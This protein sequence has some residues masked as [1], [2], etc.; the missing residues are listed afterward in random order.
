MMGVF[1]EALMKEKIRLKTGKDFAKP[2]GP[3]VDRLM[4]IARDKGRIKQ[5]GDGRN[6]IEPKGIRFLYKFRDKRNTYAYFDEAK[7]VEGRIMQAWAI[8]L[9]DKINL[10]EFVAAVKEA[11]TGKR[12][13]LLVDAKHPALRS[14]SKQYTDRM[15]AVRLFNL[16]YAFAL[17]FIMKYLRQKDYVEFNRRFLTPFVD[18][19]PELRKRN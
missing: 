7:V 4:G 15:M 18:L 14:I 19:S 17:G 3:C 5:A 9:G 16:V 1:L 13:P 11:T 12:K 6:L 8:P 10:A 2:Y